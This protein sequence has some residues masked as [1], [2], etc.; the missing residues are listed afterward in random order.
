MIML[1][2]TAEQ[3]EAFASNPN[4]LIEPTA[5]SQLSEGTLDVLQSALASA[6]H[7]VFWVGAL[8]A[9]L[10]FV[11]VLFLPKHKPGEDHDVDGERLI[12]AEQTVI[13]ARN[14]PVADEG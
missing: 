1:I 14:Q 9:G 4:A 5:K 8:M 3:A 7:P 12:M 11:V 13:N 10:G 2:L 6:I